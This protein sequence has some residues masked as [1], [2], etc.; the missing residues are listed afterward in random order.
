MTANRTLK[1]V[2]CLFLA[3]MLVTASCQNEL[4][5][6]PVSPNFTA[7]EEVIDAPTIDC[8]EKSDEVCRELEKF[9]RKA[10]KS[11]VL[12]Q[13]T[14]YTTTKGVQ[15]QYGSGVVIL[16]DSNPKICRD[17]NVSE[18]AVLTAYHV[19]RDALLITVTDREVSK[20]G[21]VI[22]KGRTIPMEIVASD[23]KLDIALLKPTKQNE[24]LPEP[25]EINRRLPDIKETVWRFGHSSSWTEGRVK[26][27]GAVVGGNQNMI[28]TKSFSWGGDSG[29]PLLDRNGQVL[30]I[31]L[32]HAI[33]KGEANIRP[34]GQILDALFPPEQDLDEI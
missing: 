27:N 34:I 23:R 26:K 15:H 9:I 19:V 22:E 7:S 4:M 21:K 2:S 6:G 24:Y 1:I 5:N 17:S 18:R 16:A 10:T 30:G 31:L 12:V 3:L 33:F 11:T 29:G 28:V 32:T 14:I 13:T 20:D 8:F 25:L